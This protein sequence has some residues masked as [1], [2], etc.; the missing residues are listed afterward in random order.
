MNRPWLVV[1]IASGDRHSE[2]REG[3]SARTCME[4]TPYAFQYRSEAVP[5]SL[6]RPADTIL[7]CWGKM[8][9]FGRSSVR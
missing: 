9:W 7:K 6:G 4:R 1:I 8:S 2:N 3:S 5:P